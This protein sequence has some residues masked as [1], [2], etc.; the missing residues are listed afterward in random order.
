[1]RIIFISILSVIS[2]CVFGQ[3]HSDINYIRMYEIS[4]DLLNKEVKIDFRP[5]QGESNIRNEDTA[6]LKIQGVNINL[7]EKRKVGMEEW[8]YGD[9]ALQPMENLAGDKIKINKTL[10]KKITQDSIL[11]EF[12][13]EFSTPEPR[14]EREEIWIYRKSLDGIIIKR[15]SR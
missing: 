8:Y 9:Q 1:M 6:Q 10:I 7:M 3:A 13:I 4:D 11:F 2:V 5:T 12:I 15:K 14:F